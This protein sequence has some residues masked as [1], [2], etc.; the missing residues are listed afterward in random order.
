MYTQ[1]DSDKGLRCGFLKKLC[2]H[3]KLFE[4]NARPL[5]WNLPLSD[6]YFFNF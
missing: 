4:P 2:L 3:K 6:L 5:L 1:G